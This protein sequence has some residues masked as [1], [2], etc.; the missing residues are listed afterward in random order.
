LRGSDAAQPRQAG[1]DRGEHVD[2]PQP[3][4]PTTQVSAFGDGQAHAVLDI[5]AAIASGQA[6]NDSAAVTVACRPGRTR[7]PVAHRSPRTWFVAALGGPK[8]EVEHP[9]V[10]PDLQGGGCDDRAEVEHRDVV[11]Q[12]MTPC[13]ARRSGTSCLRRWLPDRSASWSTSEGLIPS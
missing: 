5:A 6:V 12:A 2:L 3:F 1:H 4:G 10:V 11:A 8:V 9:G 13:C 7:Q